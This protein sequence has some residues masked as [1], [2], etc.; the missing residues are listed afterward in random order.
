MEDFKKLVVGQDIVIQRSNYGENAAFMG[1]I[2]KI[3]AT[4]FTVSAVCFGQ[5]HQVFTVNGEVY[6][7]QTGYGRTYWKL[8]KADAAGQALV[9]KS[10]AIRRIRSAFTGLETILRNSNLKCNIEQLDLNNDDARQAAEFVENA[11]QIL[12]K[13]TKD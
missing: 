5:G 8:M 4:R 11:I 1:K 9:Q 7:R 13:Y 2:T 12:N 3:T 10:I 6:P